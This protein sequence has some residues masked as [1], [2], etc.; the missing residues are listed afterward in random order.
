M[1]C[2]YVFLT[3]SKKKYCRNHQKKFALKIH[4]VAIMRV[5]SENGN[6]NKIVVLVGC[7]W[8][9]YAISHWAD[10]SVT[11]GQLVE[12]RQL[13]LGWAEFN[14]TIPLWFHVTHFVHDAHTPQLLVIDDQVQLCRIVKCILDNGYYKFTFI[15]FSLPSLYARSTNKVANFRRWKVAF[16]HC[17]HASHTH[18]HAAHSVQKDFVIA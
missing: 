12:L 8:T 5:L 14:N 10:I 13:Q 7:R 15:S 2:I 4:K 17:S 18:F 3:F 6:M 1:E 11:P 9:N 16:W